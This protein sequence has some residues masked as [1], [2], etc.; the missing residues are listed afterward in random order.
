[1]AVYEDAPEELSLLFIDFLVIGCVVTSC[2]VRVMIVAIKEVKRISGLDVVIFE[3]GI[4]EVDVIGV[5][6]SRRT[7]RVYELFIFTI[8]YCTALCTYLFLAGVRMDCV[9]TGLYRSFVLLSC[10]TFVYMVVE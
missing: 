2:F 1:M 4:Y 6:A 7:R 3:E 9:V 8:I 10:L 5:S